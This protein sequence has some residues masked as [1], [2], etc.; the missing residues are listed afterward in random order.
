MV[1]TTGFFDGVHTGHRLVIQRLVCEARDRGQK[2]LVITFWPHPRTV[3]QN[4]ARELRLLSSLEEKK[5]MLYGLGV[6]RVE[7]IDFDKAFSRLK[8]EEYLREYV[9]D[10]FGGSVVLFGYNHRLGCDAPSAP[11]LRDIAS[12]LGLEAVFVPQTSGQ[13][14][15]TLIRKALLEGDVKNAGAMLGYAYSLTGVVVAG[16]RLG[17]TIGFPTA[18]LKLYDPLKMVPA[19]GVYAV[20]AYT[21]GRSFK[22][23]CNIGFRPTVSTGGAPSI[24]TNIFG[25]DEDIYGLD[26]K[27]TFKE[28]I[29]DEIKFPSLKELAEQ[30]AKDKEMAIKIN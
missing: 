7:V 5:R 30:L 4:G 23:M 14:S 10:R 12:S 8:A 3:L 6:D 2:S 13:V 20:D 25:F 22:G 1:V 18:N 28:K 17:R 27:V 19:N 29:R 16:N 11:E 26:L 15:S 24:E 21:L 9:R